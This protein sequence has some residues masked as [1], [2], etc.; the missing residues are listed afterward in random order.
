MGSRDVRRAPRARQSLRHHRLQQAAERR[1]A[2]PRSW[3]WNR[4]PRNGARSAGTSRKSTATTSNKF[5][6]RLRSARQ[7]ATRPS[8][9]IAHTIKGKG[10]PYME[11]MPAWHGSVKLTREQAEEALVALGASTQRNRGAARCAEAP[12][13]IG[14]SGDSLREAFGKALSALAD[15]I[16]RS[17]WCW[18]PTSPAA[19]ACIISAK[20][21]PEALSA[22]RHRRAE[23]DGGGR[24]PRRR[25]P[26]AG[27]DDLRR[28]LPARRSNR[29]GCRSPMRGA[30]RRSSPAIPASTSAPTAA[31]RRRWKTSR[32]SAPFPA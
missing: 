24:R 13:L 31:R 10:V 18:M 16:S 25:R 20:S 21:H 22:V 11:D 19:P 14:T 9:I 28:V 15:R 5:S 7:R 8:V 32:R 29:R 2:T 6:P 23:H 1:R 17:L 12:A 27:G 26:A 3:A 30:T 4:S